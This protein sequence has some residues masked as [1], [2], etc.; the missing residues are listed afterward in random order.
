M[1]KLV[2][3]YVV[4]QRPTAEI[5]AQVGISYKTMVKLLKQYGHSPR[6]MPH[7]RLLAVVE[8]WGIM[9][10]LVPAA[11]D[12]L[13]SGRRRGEVARCLSISLPTLRRLVPVASHSILST[14]RDANGHQPGNV[15][16]GGRSRASPVLNARTDRH[17]T[18]VSPCALS[19]DVL[20]QGQ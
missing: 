9:D 14:S 19:R 13:A 7:A 8:R 15:C 17:L 20:I 3:L 2:Q 5:L 6:S 12:M 4:E 11:Q 18:P 10:N 16:I 1:D